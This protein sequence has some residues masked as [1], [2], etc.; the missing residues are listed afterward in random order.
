MKQAVILC[1]FMVLVLPITALGQVRT[2]VKE[3]TLTMSDDDSRNSVR[4]RAQ[5]QLRT[6]ILSEVGSFVQSNR[7]SA[8]TISGGNVEDIYREAVNISTQGRVSLRVLD[9]RFE[10]PTYWVRAEMRVDVGEINRNLER[11][12]R[13][14]EESERRRR[15]DAEN[16]ERTRRQNDEAVARLRSQIEISQ[17]QVSELE[18]R[19]AEA[20]TRRGVAT[21]SASRAKEAMD[22]AQ[23]D[24]REAVALLGANPAS[25]PAQRMVNITLE[26]FNSARRT[27]AEEEAKANTAENVWR[28]ADTDLRREREHLEGLRNQLRQLNAGTISAESVNT[29]RS[30]ARNTTLSELSDTRKQSHKTEIILNA[31]KFTRRRNAGIALMAGG[32]S[33][34]II[35][36]ALTTSDQFALGALFGVP[37]WHALAAGIPIYITGQVGCNRSKRAE[38]MMAP[39]SAFIIPNGAQFVW[40]F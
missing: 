32:F 11:K 4:A 29:Q 38:R 20:Q 1:V 19:E 5:E 6:M 33:F 28:T 27:H 3:H 35:G 14:V 26:D 16:A 21:A 25:Q 23:N 17:K 34:G 7:S 22:K 24:H 8:M 37:G 9:E 12:Q 2:F 31:E 39:S 18:A 40:N 30:S 36:V 10:G 13:E 15:L